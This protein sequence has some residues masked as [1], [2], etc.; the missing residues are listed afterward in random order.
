MS[1][2]AERSRREEQE[3][4]LAAGC[5]WELL[6]AAARS[7]NLTLSFSLAVLPSVGVVPARTSPHTAE[8]CPCLFPCSCPTPYPSLSACVISA[9]FLMALLAVNYV[10]S[11]S[12]SR[13]SPQRQL[14][15]AIK[16]AAWQLW[17]T[18]LLSAKLKSRSQR[19]LFD[20]QLMFPLTNNG[21]SVEWQPHN[22]LK[23]CP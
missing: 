22:K 23:A 10:V 21:Q 15:Y 9:Y 11:L 7:G 18:A 17:L 1:E 2:W 3:Q 19:K 12:L 4:G 20:Y 16:P 14:K 5:C 13:L 6:L 8:C